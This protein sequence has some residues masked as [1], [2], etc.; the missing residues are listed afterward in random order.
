MCKRLIG[1]TGDSGFVGDYN[2]PPA[3]EDKGNNKY[4][5]INSVQYGANL[6]QN[7]KVVMLPP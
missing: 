5:S 6:R 2:A 7:W 3:F 1:G 4:I